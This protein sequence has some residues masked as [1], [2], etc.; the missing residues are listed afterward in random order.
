MR[1]APYANGSRRWWPTV[2]H[3][4]IML[5]VRGSRRGGRN[6]NLRGQPRPPPPQQDAHVLAWLVMQAEY[7][8][9]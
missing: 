9:W 3:P 4:F 7:V 6:V 1:R 8:G 5:T 2:R